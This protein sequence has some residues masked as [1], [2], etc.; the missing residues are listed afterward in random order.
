LIGY[1]VAYF[2][3]WRKQ[4]AW[5]YCGILARVPILLI[6]RKIGSFSTPKHKRCTALLFRFEEGGSATGGVITDIRKAASSPGC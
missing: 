4:F 6:T 3:V 5:R 2:I 1:Q